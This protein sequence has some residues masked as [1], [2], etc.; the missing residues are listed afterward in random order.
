MQVDAPQARPALSL[1]KQVVYGAGEIPNAIKT[2][3]FGLFTLYFYTTVIGLPGTLVGIA[4]AIGVMWDA[5]IDPYI[6]YA[7]D[8]AKFR[9]GRRHTFMLAG[10]L[11]M[12]ATFWAFFHPPAGLSTTGLF[13][14]LLATSLLVRTAT[15]LYG[16]PYFAFGAELSSDY[17][18]RTSITA[19][20]GALG[21]LGT[22]AAASL[23]F[24][25]FFPDTTLGIDP[26]LNRAGYSE[27][28]L[29]LGAGMTLLALVVTMTT[30]RWP[31]DAA[32][33]PS[34][35][36]TVQP[37]RSFFAS[38][39]RSFANRS[40]RLLFLSYSLVFLALVINSGL[41]I[42]YLTHYV[43]IEASAALSTLQAAFYV[44]A[45]MGV[46]FW[47]WSSRRVEKHWV[48]FLALLCVAGVLLASLYLVGDGRVVGVGNVRA[49]AIG[50]A[51]GGFF[52]SVLWFI[53]GSMIADV[54][55]EDSLGTGQRREGSFFGLF[56]FGQQ[57]AASVALLAT[58]TL[59]ERFA[60]LHAGQ[61][62]PSPVTVYRIAVLYGGLP[63]VLVLVA[64]SLIL[65]YSLTR[66]RVRAIQCGLVQGRVP[67]D[68]RSARERQHAG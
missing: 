28:G 34:G 11:T 36:A 41:S 38:F 46:G 32:A 26:K 27:M 40:F 8:N 35:G 12:G 21:L 58:G 55:D 2:I 6:G 19:V 62:E 9:F 64:A 49:L 18:E 65:G 37:P 1:W 7:S 31:T 15:S 10:A 63:A 59:I 51:L 5:I 43:R 17:Q 29:A 16:V 48:Y 42:H 13:A 23:S 53:P 56:Y 30:R 47:L 39:V 20:R 4:S 44:G 14:W 22:M 61:S 24:V 25:V 66:S 45:L 52:G 68:A 33:L 60:G 50:H 3:G 54:A 57:I 67:A